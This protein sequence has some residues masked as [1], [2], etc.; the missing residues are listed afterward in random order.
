MWESRVASLARVVRD[1]IDQM[2]QFGIISLTE[3]NADQ[4]SEIAP[5]GARARAALSDIAMLLSGGVVAFVIALIYLF[6][7]T[8]WGATDTTNFDSTLATALLLAVPPTS[9]A[10]MLL[11]LAEYRATPGQLREG[12][13]VVSREGGL[14]WGLLLRIAM[15]PL[16][17]P[18]WLWLTAILSLLAVPVL[19]R[20]VLLWSALVT[21]DGLLSIVLLVLRPRTPAIHDLLAQTRV[22]IRL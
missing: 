4:P 18:F 20:L 13:V 21:I 19:P 12:L 11:S 10:W 6:I 9:M 16:N 2:I 17:L 15:H 22:V 14:R 5:R 7:R 3:N 1:I 8:G